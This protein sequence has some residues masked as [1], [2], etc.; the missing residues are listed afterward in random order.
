MNKVLIKRTVQMIVTTFFTE[1]YSLSPKKQSEECA[2]NTVP[3]C[4]KKTKT[5]TAFSAIF[6]HWDG[7]IIN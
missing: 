7:S 6:V 5:Q 1:F 4:Q 3:C 2:Q